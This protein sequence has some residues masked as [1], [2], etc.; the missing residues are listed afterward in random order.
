MLKHEKRRLMTKKN[1]DGEFSN[2]KTTMTETH[3]N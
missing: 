2:G 1:T 3:P